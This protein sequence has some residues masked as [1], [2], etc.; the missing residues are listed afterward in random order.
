MNKGEHVNACFMRIIELKDQFS[1]VGYEIE[2]KELSLTTLGRLPTSREPFKQ[3]ISARSKLPKL[4]WLTFD[5]LQEEARL[6]PKGIKHKSLD[7][8]IQVLN[9]NTKNKGK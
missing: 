4:D 1:N 3:G 2:S 7:E 5:C 9:T 8:D 6:S